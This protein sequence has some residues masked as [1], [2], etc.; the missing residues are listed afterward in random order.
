MDGR[1]LPH[2]GAE[3]EATLMVIFSSYIKIKGPVRCSSS[4]QQGYKRRGLYKTNRK[5]SLP[6]Y[7]SWNITHAWSLL[8]FRILKVQSCR[9]VVFYEVIMNNLQ[10]YF[11]E[12]FWIYFCDNGT[13]TMKQWTRYFSEMFVPLY[14]ITRQ[15]Y[16]RTPSCW[17]RFIIFDYDCNF[18][19]G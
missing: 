2:W 19:L 13:W 12:T 1:Q 15:L 3:I 11:E 7:G 9:I 8:K 14:Q 18:V 17:K 16:P 6:F 5:M 10:G 4:T